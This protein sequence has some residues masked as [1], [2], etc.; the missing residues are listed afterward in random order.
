M[1]VQFDLFESLDSVAIYAQKVEKQNFIGN[2]SAVQIP[3]L[4]AALNF[5]VKVFT[6]VKATAT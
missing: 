3:N 6:T 5:K 2:K 1:E 4:I